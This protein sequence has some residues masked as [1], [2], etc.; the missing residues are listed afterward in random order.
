MLAINTDI[1]ASTIGELVTYARKNPGKLTFSSSGV[2]TIQH[3]TGEVFNKVAGID[4]LHVPY[5]GAAPAT[6]DVA[7]KRVS[8]TFSSPGLIAPFVQKGQIKMLGIVM[9]KRYPSLKELPTVQETPGMEAFDVE[10]WFA[11]FAPANTPPEI[12][13]RL[14]TEIREAMKVPAIAEKLINNVG[15]PSFEDEVQA[16]QFV[17]SEARKYSRILKELD[18]KQ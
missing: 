4:V 10:S 15:M 16:K 14:N 8:M 11:M 17:A 7:S 2:G 13:R 9:S 6:V 18:I 5:A 3:I 12:V 1:P